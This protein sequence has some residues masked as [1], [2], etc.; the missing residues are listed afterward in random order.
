LLNVALA[1]WDAGLMA[2]K[3]TIN[4]NLNAVVYIILL[5]PVFLISKNWVLIASLCLD[6]LLF[7]NI[8][9]NLYRKLKWNYMPQFP[10]SKV[11][12]ISNFI[13]FRNGYLQYAVYGILF[14]YTLTKLPL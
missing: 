6:R 2:D 9:L 11:D 12:M 13:F 4:H 14:I 8:S 5:V 3:K 7:F 1:Q 10:N